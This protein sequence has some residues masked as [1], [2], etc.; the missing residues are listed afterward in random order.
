MGTGFEDVF[1]ENDEFGWGGETCFGGF[2]RGVELDVDV[3]SGFTGW[4]E[5]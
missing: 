5:R 4:C 1:G 2:V 3:Q